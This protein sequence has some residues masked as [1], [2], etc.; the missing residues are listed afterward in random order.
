MRSSTAITAKGRTARPLIFL[1]AVVLTGI[2][3]AQNP[4][5][6][7][8]E[9][10]FLDAP[11][12]TKHAV[13]MTGPAVGDD[14]AARFRQWS[15]SLYDILT[16]DYGYSSETITLLYDDGKDDFTGGDRVDGACSREGIEFALERLAEHVKTGDQIT[17]FLIG[18]GSGAEE[19]AK[20]N[21]VGPDLTGVQFAS[22]LDRFHQQDMIVINTTSASFGFSSSLSSV[23]RVVISSTRSSSERYDPVFAGYFIEALDQRNGDRDKNKRVSMLE[24]FVYAKAN[25][26]LWYEEQDRLASEHSGL[27]D[28]GD[29]LFSLDPAID[30]ADGRLAEIAYIDSLIEEGEKLSTE[31]LALKSRIQDLER[32]VIVLRGKKAEYLEAEYWQQMED[33]LV[34][35]ALSTAR[36]N[37]EFKPTS[38]VQESADESNESQSTLD[39]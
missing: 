30:I 2:T 28:N 4:A 5:L 16:R 33:L 10:R 17:L 3:R 25:V 39:R 6:D 12:T 27:D 36:F 21:I 22:L 26:E 37:A 13:I 9:R 29:A 19:E 20:F 32:S 34:N 24:A 11:T 14:N 23:G 7:T 31:G 35:L 15:L 38:S 8:S 1:C 18:H